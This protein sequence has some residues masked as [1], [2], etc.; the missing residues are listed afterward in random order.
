MELGHGK[1]LVL[2]KILYN[3]IGDLYM[4]KIIVGMF[5]KAGSGKDTVA[6]YICD[7]Y[8]FVRMALADP[9]KESIKHMFCLDDY[10][11]YN[12]KA[13]EEPLPDFPEWSVRKL[14][15]FIG[16][17]LMR[18][19]FDD[20]FWAKLLN[21]RIIK[22]QH[23]RIIVTDVRFPNEADYLYALSLEQ[24]Y[25]VS[26]IKVVRDGCVGHDVGIINH[27]SEKY[28]LPSDYVIENND[29]FEVLYDEVDQVMYKIFGDYKLDIQGG[30]I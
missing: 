1:V 28:D 9:L 17:D 8:N 23:P 2:D 29:T 25:S 19:Q 16:T 30:L 5:G 3:K 11:V 7:K 22:S 21:K 24:K 12:R 27:E 26:C 4:K 15:Q 10:T 18:K 13:R 6:D 14:F 20:A